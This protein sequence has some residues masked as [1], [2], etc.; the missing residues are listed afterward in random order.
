M[1]LTSAPTTEVGSASFAASTV[2]PLATDVEP[3]TVG[4]RVDRA[5]G[6]S[7]ATGLVA[8]SGGIIV[9]ASSAVDGA[10]SITVTEP[11]GSSLTGTLV[12]T[13]AASGLSVVRIADDLQPATYDDTNPVVGKWALA[14]SLAPATR[15]G[16]RPAM[17]VY[18][19]TVSSIA[20]TGTRGLSTIDVALPLSPGDIGCPLIDA[21][22]EVAGLLESVRVAGHSRVSVFLPAELVFHVV[23]QLVESGQVNQGWLGVGLEGTPATP[24]TE[25][26]AMVAAVAPDSP[27]AYGG[28]AAGDLITA[29]DGTPVRSPADLRTDM[30][31]I[32]PGTPIDLGYTSPA[33]GSVHTSVV[34]AS[35]GSGAPVLSA[36]P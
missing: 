13:D 15:R 12:A 10:R 2:D 27:A 29:I 25:P 23:Q 3:S 28:L 34:L 32:A 19:G 9:T 20:P 5:G 30:Y 33:L 31:A 14:M 22:G 35:D 26:G 17:S 1:R 6:T 8:M 24:A 11:G 4:L 7:V 18:A 21:K 36:S 16:A